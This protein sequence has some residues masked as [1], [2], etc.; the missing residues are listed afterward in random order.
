MEDNSA[1]KKSDPMKMQVLR[2]LPVDIKQSLTK[3]EVSAFLHDEE[4]PESLSD[5]LKDYLVD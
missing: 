4:W 2:M 1:N 3:E 5:K